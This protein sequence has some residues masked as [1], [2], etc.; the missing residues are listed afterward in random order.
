MFLPHTRHIL[1]VGSFQDNLGKAVYKRMSD[2]LTAV[3]EDGD[4]WQWRYWIS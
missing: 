1:F 2:H 4:W 3:R